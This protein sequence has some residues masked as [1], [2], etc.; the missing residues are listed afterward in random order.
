MFNFTLTD[1]DSSCIKA[2][3]WKNNNLTIKYNNGKIYMYIGVPQDIIADLART[4]SVGRWIN[5][6]IKPFYQFVKLNDEI[7]ETIKRIG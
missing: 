2:I 3:D 6:D 7:N 1:V 5:K 4:S